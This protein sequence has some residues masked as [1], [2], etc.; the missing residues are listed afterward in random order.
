[1]STAETPAVGTLLYKAVSPDLT[2]RGG[3]RW[4]PGTTVTH[5]TSTGMV[6]D[7]PSTY[8]SLSTEPAETLIG[9][10]WPAR[11]LRVE[12]LG[13]VTT[14]DQ[15]RHKRCVLRARVV[16]ELESWRVLG[17]NG[18]QVAALLE[19]ASQLTTGDVQRL[20]TA[21]DAAWNAAWVA[22][23][24]AVWNAARNAA[25]DAAR[26]AA[27]DAAWDVARDAAWDA[28]RALVVRDLLVGEHFETLTRPWVSV[29]GPL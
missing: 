22:A 15:Y 14:S 20:A 4:E 11:L 9:R 24:D 6:R 25:R 8:L 29:M 27:R 5:P 13:E 7:D 19:R 28:A 26:V 2:S 12:P 18:E 3:L 23:R 1:M 21:W 17:P 16:D 10:S